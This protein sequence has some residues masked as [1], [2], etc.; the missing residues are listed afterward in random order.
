MKNITRVL[1]LLLA[2]ILVLGLVVTGFADG[3]G[4]TGPG[5]ITIN[6]AVAGQTYTIYKIL[7][8]ESYDQAPNA[9][10]YAYKAAE[11]WKG[12]LNTT[13]AKAY[14]TVGDHDYVTWVN[15]NGAT[16]TSEENRAAEFAK[17][18]LAYAKDSTHPITSNGSQTVTEGNSSVEFSNLPLGYYLVDSSVGTL[19]FL[20]TT[21]SEV[22]IQE[23]NKAPTN[24]KQVQEDSKISKTDEYGTEND[25][26]IGQT[27]NFKSTIIA[28]AGAQNYVFHDTMSAGLTFNGTVTVTKGADAVADTSYT[29]K[30]KNDADE[31]NKPTDSCTFEIVFDQTFCDSLKA[32]EQIVIAYSA[33][34]NENA[35][36][37]GNGN[38]N[39]CKLTY[40][41][42]NNLETQPAKT[43]TYTWG[44]DVLKYANGQETDT[45]ANVEFVL[46]NKATNKVASHS[47]G[48]ITRWGDV[49]ANGTQ[50]DATSILKTGPDGKISIKG[51]DTDT[52]LLRETKG[53]PGY[54]LLVDDIEITIGNNGEVKIKEGNALN[55]AA[56]DAASG[57]YT[58]KVENKSGTLM[59]STGGIGTTV[60]YVVGGIL[61]VGAAVLLVT[62]KRMERG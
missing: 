36:I 11:N 20:N 32:G 50:W 15:G 27:V 40:G 62:K 4:A 52:Y 53:L 19:C 59:P 3:A 21:N 38:T 33:T 39:V 9:N 45:L 8:L 49:P 35:V 46:L 22:T 12:F 56:Q 41:E 58:I 10:R 6:N 5:K 13:E 7:E 31:S 47:E 16:T 51:L 61:A 17:L 43:T 18:A 14:M 57:V 26:D 30:T 60:F 28:Q 48:K 34:L 55:P 1:A 24:T 25:A 23:K 54:N 42:N 29:L 2:L 44:F 37:A